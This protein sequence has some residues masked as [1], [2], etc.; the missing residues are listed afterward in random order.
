MKIVQI[1]ATCGIG[2][3]G[4]ICIGVSE[5]LSEHNVEN[6][7]LCSRSNGYHLGIPCA[8]TND[9][10]IQALKSKIFGNYGFNSRKATKK[11]IGELEKIQPDV[12]HLHNIHGHDCNLEMLF[13]YFN[14]KK[15]KLVWTFHDCWA[16]T[17]Y[18]TYFDFP[19]CDRW[20]TKCENCAKTREHS[21]LFDRSS[22]LF[23]KK[24]KLFEGL[25]L[26]IVT[27][28][29]WLADLVK[30][31][32]LKDYPVRVI[33]NGIDLNVFKPT[34][35]G[36]REKY[37]LQNKKILLG[38]S[39]VWDRRKGLDVF[40]AL[41]IRL[42]E[43]Y[44]IVLVGTS[45]ETD[46]RLSGN[47]VSIHRTQNQKELAEIYSAADLFVIPTREENYP[48]VNMEALACGTPVLT[49]RTGGSPEILD[50]ACG[51]VVDCG[52]VDA[53]EREIIRIFEK[54]P[55]TEESCLKK[56]GS[57]DQNERFK[58]YVDLYEDICTF[59]TNHNLYES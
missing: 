56:A 2:S 30:Q 47:I 15:T 13:T 42:P 16:F 23:E 55:Y 27:P 33:N 40:E 45:E 3:T 34:K 35:S 29:Q 59:A 48:T 46:K 31:S 25:D 51:A 28:S 57:F 43:D 41:S 49:F 19:K 6:Y 5:I 12:V 9:I 4:K 20:K 1:N 8:N 11:M 38:V 17:G 22:I 18:C 39:F 58:E 21:F 14:K 50:E 26:T 53:L 36:F 54:K 7:I 44:K 32:F 24:K 52:D 10:R 37:G